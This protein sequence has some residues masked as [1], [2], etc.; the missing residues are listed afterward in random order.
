VNDYLSTSVVAAV[1]VPPDGA[2]DF[3]G[4]DEIWTQFMLNTS[5]RF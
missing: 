5:I 2:Q 4:N 3:F 1:L